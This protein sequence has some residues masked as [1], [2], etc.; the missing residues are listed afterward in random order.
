M[1]TFCSLRAWGT[2]EEDVGDCSPLLPAPHEKCPVAQPLGLGCYL[3]R[4]WLEPR[5][6][7]GEML[8]EC[9]RVACLL[10]EAG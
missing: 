8:A 3:E 7:T 6:S 5:L 2:L 9:R 4:S 10:G 1:P